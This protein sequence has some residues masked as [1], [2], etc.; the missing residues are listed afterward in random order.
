MLRRA[1]LLLELGSCGRLAIDPRPD[2]TAAP[3]IERGTCTLPSGATL[4]SCPAAMPLGDVAHAALFFQA[5]SASTVPGGFDVRCQLAG[6]DAIACDRQAAN[7]APA[8]IAWQTLEDDARIAVQHVPF[9]CD[10]QT[11][12]T[13]PIAAV[14]PTHAFVLG[15]WTEQGSYLN[16]DDFV[17][18]EL[19]TSSVLLTTGSADSCGISGVGP[20]QGALEVVEVAGASVTRG[21]AGPIASNA[22]TATVSALPPVDPASTALLFTY[23]SV[24]ANVPVCQLMVR[25]EITS[26][27]TLSFS[28]GMADPSCTG[29]EIEAISWERI[30]FGSLANVQPFTID[31][32][33]GVTAATAPIAPIDP[34]RAIVLS[35]AQGVSGQ[36]TG[37]GTFSNNN[38]GGELTA[39][40]QL[41]PDSV[42]VTRA[43]ANASARFTGQVIEWHP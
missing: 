38:L 16:D 9:T 42:V 39:T 6:T 14:D 1:L 28:R 37:E 27:T 32:G 23:T 34:T 31:L 20:M 4:V 33:P 41:Q 13:I 2:A 22:L 11:Q 21:V 15:S 18:L 8:P 36:G 5:S 17:T 12:F 29:P 19:S 26:A 40:F 10:M 3:P 25:G 35:T 30:D 24:S 7:V 43:T